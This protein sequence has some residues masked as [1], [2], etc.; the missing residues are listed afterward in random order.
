MRTFAKK[1]S[2]FPLVIIYQYTATYHVEIQFNNQ[3]TKSDFVHLVMIQPDE[4]E[5]PIVEDK[6]MLKYK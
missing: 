6:I 4:P 3:N 2:V 1:L 5:L